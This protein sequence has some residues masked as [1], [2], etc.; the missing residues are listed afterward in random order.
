M[1]WVRKGIVLL[2]SLIFFVALFLG[3]VATSVNVAIAKPDK[4]EAWLSESKL[5]D[6]FISSVI[7]QAQDSSKTNSNNS[8]NSQNNSGQNATNKSSSSTNNN[9]SSDS[10]DLTDPGVKEAAEAAFPAAQL[11][12]YVNTVLNANYAW[13]EGKTATPAFTID[14]TTAKN[15]FAQQVGAAVTTHLSS[16]AV[17]TPAQ[18]AA[19]PSQDPLV[20]TCRPAGVNPAAAGAKITAKLAGSDGPFSD[21]VITAATISSKNGAK[22]Y[23]V[24]FSIA[25]KAY[26]WGVKVPWAFGLLALLC[27][28]GIIFIAPRKRKGLRRVAWVLTFAG[29]LLIATQFAANTAVK[30]IEKQAFNN[31][32]NGDLQQ[33]LTNLI[34]LAKTQIEKIDTYFGIGFLVIAAIIFIILIATKQRKPK[35][36]RTAKSSTTETADTPVQEAPVAAQANRSR[37][38]MDVMSPQPKAASTAPKLPPSAVSKPPKRPRLIQ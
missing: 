20:V 35:A 22:A 14:L 9:G 37:P 29:V 33:S 34:Q 18:L 17:C 38:V 10:I 12:Q 32:T 28:L 15:T 30:Y 4:I 26:S 8:G 11:Q 21:S 36:T 23:Y 24:K 5:Y 3:V 19:L 31:S 25:P 1:I 13:L 27:A 16:L 2:L 6:H 7:K